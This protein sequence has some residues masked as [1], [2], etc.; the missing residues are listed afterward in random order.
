MAQGHLSKTLT[1]IPCLPK[2]E[3]TPLHPPPPPPPRDPSRGHSIPSPSTSTPCDPSRRHPTPLSLH[4]LHPR[5]PS[6]RHPTPLSL[7]LHPLRPQ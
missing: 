5:D 4:P 1:A 7:H 3:G 2:V 6:R